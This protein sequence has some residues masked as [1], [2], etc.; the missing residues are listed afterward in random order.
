[1]NVLSFLPVV[2]KLHPDR[3]ALS[4]GTELYC[5]YRQLMSWVACLA[6]AM[7]HRLGLNIGD[8]VGI[9]MKNCPASFEVLL[10]AWQAG[11][12]AV[13]INAKL[14]GQEF[15]FILGNCD[16]KA[17]FATS[18]AAQ[19]IE[20][21]RD[22]NR[23]ACRVV[24]VED[25]EYEELL[26]AEPIGMHDAGHLDPAWL[27]YTSGTTGH[28]KG[29]TLSHRSLVNMLLRYYADV[30]FLTEFD[31]MIHAAPLSHGSGLYALPHLAKASHQV[32]TP[33]QGFET[34]ELLD[35][36]EEYL[37]VTFFAAP[38]MLTRMVAHPNTARVKIDHIK[39]IYYGGSP[40]Y[41][42]DLKRAIRAFG[43]CLYQGYGQ[44]ETPMTATGLSKA[45]HADFD[46]PKYDHRL[47]S[48]GSVRSGVEVRIF[49]PED[50]EVPIGELGEVVVRSDVTMLGY[51]N[52]PAANAE[53]LRGG[54]LRTGDIG[55]FDEDGF[56]TLKDRSKDLIISGGTNIY[57][58]EVEEVLI[59]HPAVSEIAVVGRP[60][61][62]WGEEVVAFI[63][64]RSGTTVSPEDLDR[65][66]VEHM[67][68][69]KRPKDYIFADSL[70]KNN[71]GKVLKTELRNK[72]GG[73][74]LFT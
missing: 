59:C 65:F 71:Y 43:P 51:W 38:T 53:T 15:A 13:P 11:L 1:M 20:Q 2:A 34:P 24:C 55:C 64:P 67:S 70:P 50:R 12:C 58:R 35:L 73:R 4:V 27:F 30:D 6:G 9:A 10:A 69:F 37:N 16:A 74:K 49:D 42:A 44:G 40:M 23:L 32:I 28:P 56:L 18:E 60:H 54:W 19:S 66:C 72:L 39:T 5:T 31:T 57:P 21:F 26:A 29:A 33:S 17:C 52:N 14:H 7:R 36:I 3:P 47:A 8:R 68:R 62:D 61:D 41:V 25:R 48:V 63:V 45:Q 22:A 46:H